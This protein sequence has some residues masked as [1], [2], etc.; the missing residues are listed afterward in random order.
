MQ[1]M[2]FEVDIGEGVISGHA[3]VQSDSRGGQEEPSVPPSKAAKPG[4]ADGPAINADGTDHEGTAGL[5]PEETLEI[6]LVDG[7]RVG[8]EMAELIHLRSLLAMTILDS[9]MDVP[10]YLEEGLCGFIWATHFLWILD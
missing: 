6:I 3:M 9:D 5:T 1:H 10:P 7:L 2:S 4:D 8:V